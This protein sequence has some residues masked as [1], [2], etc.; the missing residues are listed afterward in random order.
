MIKLALALAATL[1]VTASYAQEA[2]PFSMEFATPADAARASQG[3]DHTTTFSIGRI[4]RKG[5]SDRSGSVLSIGQFKSR[6]DAENDRLN[7]GGR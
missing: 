4:S 5:G 2:P 3:V 6:I 7:Y 1:F